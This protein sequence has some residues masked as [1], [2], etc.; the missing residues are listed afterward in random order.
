MDTPNPGYVYVL[1]MDGHEYYKIGRTSNLSQRV[2]QIRPQMPTRLR[3]I[4]AH[5][6]ADCYF[7][8]SQLHF[9]YRDKR[10]NGE[11]FALNCLDLEAIKTRLLA[12]QAE[13]FLWFITERFQDRLGALSL[14][15]ISRYGRVISLSARRADRRIGRV[16]DLHDRYQSYCPAI[17]ADKNYQ[18]VI[19]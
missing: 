1:Q 5:R 16:F 9:D 13:W 8:E 3:V 17:I 15:A 12:S 4:F 7:W 2:C 19:G 11:W 6:V 18:G 10:L 14:R